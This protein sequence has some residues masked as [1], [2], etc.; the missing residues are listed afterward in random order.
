[1]TE[2][3]EKR[4]RPKKSTNTITINDLL[5]EYISLKTDKFNNAIN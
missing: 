4:G 3:T 2:K 1:M 5:C